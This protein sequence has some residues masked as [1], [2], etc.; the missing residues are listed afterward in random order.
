VSVVA[1]TKQNAANQR[2]IWVRACPVGP[3]SIV[4]TLAA[5][6]L[7]NSRLGSSINRSYVILP[8]IITECPVRDGG[9]FVRSSV[10]RTSIELTLAMTAM[11]S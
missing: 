11:P 5:A 9:P 3:R 10:N 1:N 8:H 7:L 4:Q 6:A 2:E